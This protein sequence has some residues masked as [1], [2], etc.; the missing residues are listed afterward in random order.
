MCNNFRPHILA[1]TFN[2]D[3]IKPKDI[4]PKNWVL[5]RKLSNTG[6]LVTKLSISEGHTV[7]YDLMIFFAWIKKIVDH[8]V[9]ISAIFMITWF[10]SWLFS[11]SC[12]R[13]SPTQWSREEIFLLSI[14]LGSSQLMILR[15]TAT[16]F[17]WSPSLNH[18]ES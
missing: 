7:F 5:Q 1:K 4:F 9:L 6:L 18:N 13:S 11:W 17:W 2:S 12:R 8:V 15:S 3:E 14:F 16:T 10:W